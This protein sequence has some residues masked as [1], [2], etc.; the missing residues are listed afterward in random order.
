MNLDSFKN[1]L[2]FLYDFYMNDSKLTFFN[3]E[4]FIFLSCFSLSFYGLG[5]ISK[6]AFENFL[7]YFF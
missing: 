4:S 7:C 1:L 6:L 3:F 5:T 2:S